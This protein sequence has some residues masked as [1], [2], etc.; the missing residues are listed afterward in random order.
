M[1]KT[2]D[3]ARSTIMT[4]QSGFPDGAP[5][6]ADLNTPDLAG[7]QRFYGELLGW[8][9]DPSQEAM[10]HYS[11]ARRD[12]KSVAGVAPKMPGQDWPT[13][14]SVYLMC[15]DVDA[16][17][18]KI[19]AGGGRLMFEPMDIPGQGRMLFAF[20]A[21]G[22]GFGLWQPGHHRGAELY[23]APGA[24]CWSEVNTREGARADSFYRSLFP[25]EQQQVGDGKNFDYTVWNVGGKSVC[26]RMQ[27]T[28]EWGDL[29][30]HW[31]VYFG[32]SGTDAAAEAV[33]A[34]GGKVLHGPFDSPYGRT[35]VVSD[36]Y[37]A[38]FSIIDGAQR[39][40]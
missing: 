17:A 19:G 18:Q 3:T 30:P 22:A 25:Y 7:A 14:W 5:C 16:A 20:D 13:M 11:I 37:G 24:I 39:A 27:M 32:V 36:P 29:P 35:A 6:W 26:G 9:F 21:T 4:Q 31:M 40:S 2:R 8:S 12:G 28:P 23:D 15:R 38:V 33:K 34:L 10:G 1:H